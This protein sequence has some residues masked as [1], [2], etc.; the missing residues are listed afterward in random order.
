MQGLSTLTSCQGQAK[1]ATEL[2]FFIMKLS[3]PSE[4]PSP[5]GGAKASIVPV[6]LN[7]QPE[8]AGIVID[9]ALFAH[10]KVEDLLIA[11]VEG[12]GV[13]AAGLE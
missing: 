3:N 12:K 1:E 7:P 9:I 10:D 6:P 2:I 13:I 4:F 11:I 8:L 5:Q